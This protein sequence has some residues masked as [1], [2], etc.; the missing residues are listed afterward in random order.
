MESPFQAARIGGD[1]FAVLMPNTDERGGAAMIDAIR[2]LV[3]MNNQ[4]YPA[5]R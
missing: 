2:Q 3:E 1:E 4:F 5:R